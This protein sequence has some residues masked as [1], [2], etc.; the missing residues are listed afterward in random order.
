MLYRLKRFFRN[1]VYKILKPLI[2]EVI[3]CEKRVWGPIDR[4]KISPTAKVNNTYFNT[5]S[6]RIEIGDHSFTGFDV[7]LITGKHLYKDCILE[8]RQHKAYVDG[9]DIIVGK[10]V[11]ICSRAVVLGPCKIGDHAVIAAGAVVTGDVSAYSMVAGIPAKNIKS[12]PV[13]DSELQ[14]IFDRS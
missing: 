6:G 8:E 7:M 9:Q 13:K 11:W 14:A 3:L 2:I 5:A 10:G 4:L 12:L 1:I